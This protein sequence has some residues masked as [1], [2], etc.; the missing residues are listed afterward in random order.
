MNKDI[1]GTIE[2][3]IE[4]WGRN[5]SQTISVPPKIVAKGQKFRTHRAALANSLNGFQMRFESNFRDRKE[6]LM[7]H[8]KWRFLQLQITGKDREKSQIHTY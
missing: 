4:D 1:A 3:T 6:M 8:G 5:D 7:T 2:I